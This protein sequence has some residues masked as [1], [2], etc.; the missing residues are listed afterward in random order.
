MACPK[1]FSGMIVK[2]QL[3]NGL[4]MIGFDNFRGIFYDPELK[5]FNLIQRLAFTK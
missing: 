4:N 3:L 1:R 5:I 2:N